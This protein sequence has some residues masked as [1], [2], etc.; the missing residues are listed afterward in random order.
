MKRFLQSFTLAVF[1]MFSMGL[2]CHAQQGPT[3]P[4]VVLT[5]TQ[6]TTAGITG[7]CVYRGTVSGTYSLP[8]ICFKP[9][10]TYTDTTPTPGTTYY[11]AVTAQAGAAE[12]AY[13]V[14]AQVAVPA[15]PNAPT[16]LTA[17]TV[18]WNKP[19]DIHGTNDAMN[20]QARVELVKRPQD[21]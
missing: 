8:G 11:Y 19:L 18:T 3:Q 10:T 9:G 7:N 21:K 12:S 1:T 16:G 2:T 20:L 17:P 14:P 13:S 15:N 6:S 4:T 5:W